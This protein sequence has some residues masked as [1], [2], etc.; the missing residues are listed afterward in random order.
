MANIEL[1]VP[2][3]SVV[4]ANRLLNSL[5]PTDL[6]EAGFSDQDIEDF[7]DFFLEVRHQAENCEEC[8]EHE[9]A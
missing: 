4:L 3:R 1:T 2:A 7:A 9:H 5:T 6:R 8:Q